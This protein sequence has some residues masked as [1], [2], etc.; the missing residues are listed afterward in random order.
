[1]T[2]LHSHPDR[3]ADPAGR[4]RSWILS[5]AWQIFAKPFSLSACRAAGRTSSA[6]KAVH[7]A[8][9]TAKLRRLRH[10]P[11]HRTGARNVAPSRPEEE[12]QRRES[13][14]AQFPQRPLILGDKWDF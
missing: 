4:R 11:T 5:T 7:R 2:M 9:V 6:F 3:L 10:E 8:I 14:A 13:G 12:C 1:M